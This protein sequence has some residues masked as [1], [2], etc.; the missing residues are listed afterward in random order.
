MTGVGGVPADPTVSLV[1]AVVLNVTSTGASLPSF[2]T[3]WPSGQLR[4]EASNLN[5]Q[6]G[7]DTPNLVIV[8]VGPDGGVSLYN[9]AGTGH[10]VVDVMGWFSTGGDFT[11]MIPERLLDTRT[12]AEMGPAT[13]VDVSGSGLFPGQAAVLNVT[14]TGSST[15]SFVTVWPSGEP[16]PNASNLNTQ[17]GQDTP[18]LVIAKVGANGKVSLYNDAGTGHLVVDVLGWFFN[19]AG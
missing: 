7:Q 9:D 12:T 5:T 17:P 14:S 13:M 15:P 19:P 6:P 18:N 8:G 10:L 16:R 2:V 11:P 1:K 4:P 3:V